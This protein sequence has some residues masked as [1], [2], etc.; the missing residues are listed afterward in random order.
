MLGVKFKL[1][2]FLPVQSFTFP[3]EMALAPGSGFF[4]SFSITGGPVK[5][6]FG[7]SGSAVGPRGLHF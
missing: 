2:L 7:V 1:Q 4:N 5:H 6:S 3:A